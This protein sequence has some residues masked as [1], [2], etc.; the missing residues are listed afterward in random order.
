MRLV[1]VNGAIGCLARMPLPPNLTALASTVEAAA[2][3]QG[4]NSEGA[5]GGIS[6]LSSLSSRFR[7]CFLFH[8]CPPLP[9]SAV[10]SIF[11][12]HYPPDHLAPISLLSGD[13]W[14]LHVGW[15]I[16]CSPSQ[17]GIQLDLLTNTYNATV[18]QDAASTAAS[19]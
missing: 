9:T 14:H 13:R 7:C 6:C 11:A 18:I 3:P 4:G 17:F 10:L 15:S 2:D 12:H 1:Q 19:R 16:V 5:A 8:P